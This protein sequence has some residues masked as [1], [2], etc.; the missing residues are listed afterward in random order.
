MTGQN[1]QLTRDVAELQRR[2]RDLVQGVDERLR[3]IAPHLALHR[4]ELLA[5]QLGRST[6]RAGAFEP[7]GRIPDSLR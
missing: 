6:G 2:Q 7:P 4:I 5:E 3:K 1:E